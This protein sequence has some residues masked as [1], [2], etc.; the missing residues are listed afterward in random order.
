MMQ[1]MMRIGLLFLSAI[2]LLLPGCSRDVDTKMSEKL[3]TMSKKQDEI[4]DLLKR[5]GGPGGGRG[6]GR[7]QR[8]R[9]N[10]NDVYAVPLDEAPSVGPKDAKVTM[11]EAFEFA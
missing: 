7:P 8:A 9:A 3:D 4:I 2:G 10:P 6:A 5:G 1:P 11:V